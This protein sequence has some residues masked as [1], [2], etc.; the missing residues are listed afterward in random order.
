MNDE[1]RDIIN[2]HLPAQVG[3]ALKQRLIEV[4]QTSE[5]LKH[6]L[7]AIESLKAD[8]ENLIGRVAA[9]D[10]ILAREKALVEGEASLAQSFASHEVLVAVQRVR[11]EMTQKMLD[12][13]QAVVM[14]VFAN[15]RY[16]YQENRMDGHAFPG[17]PTPGNAYPC[18][19]QVTTVS[20]RT[21]V[22]E[23]GPT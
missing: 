10:K 2:K 22:S 15:S 3:D 21:V 11:E 18:P 8:R 19:Q 9:A 23:S 6:A 16:K 20:E 14:A 5:R 17:V 4:D 13:N 1:I 7:V 12:N